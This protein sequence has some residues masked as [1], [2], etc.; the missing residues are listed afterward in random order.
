M[1]RGVGWNRAPKQAPTSVSKRDAENQTERVQ[2]LTRFPNRLA[3]S[4][5]MEESCAGVFI[6]SAATRTP[7]AQYDWYEAEREADEPQQRGRHMDDPNIVWGQ[8]PMRSRSW[9]STRSPELVEIGPQGL[10]AQ[11]MG[12]IVQRPGGS[13]RGGVKVNSYCNRRFDRP[14]PNEANLEP[15]LTPHPSGCSA[16][17]SPLNRPHLLAAARGRMWQSRTPRNALYLLHR[18]SSKVAL[19]GPKTTV[20]AP[21]STNIGAKSVTERSARAATQDPLEWGL[22][23]QIFRCGMIQPIPTPRT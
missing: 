8:R 17:P 21:I 14:S 16:P 12:P 6:T 2:F 20:R 9:G 7:A 3:T 22:E 15:E 19:G 11:S 5:H 4:T 23:S 1:R 18:C 10:K 13:G